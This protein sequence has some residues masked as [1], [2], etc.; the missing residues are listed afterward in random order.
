M[1]RTLS[2][3]EIETQSVLELPNREM[4]ALV[5]V[6]ITNVANNLT[7]SI[8]V[9][10]NKVAVQVCAVVNLLTTILTPPNALT[11]TIGQ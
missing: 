2:F 3:E 4:L 10:N 5:N 8:P 11:C 1:K 6:F 7:V 9:Q